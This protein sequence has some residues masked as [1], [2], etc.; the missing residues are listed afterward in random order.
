M[1]LA[2]MACAVALALSNAEIKTVHVINSCHLDV[3]F[4]SP[5]D[6]T[7]KGPSASS[8][9]VVNL[10][11]DKHLPRAAAV[12]AELRN[13][14]FPQYTDTKLAFMFQSWIIDLFFDCPAGLGVHCPSA[15]AMASVRAAILEGDITWH[16][17]PHNAQ[18]EI[19]DPSLIEA[20]LELTSAIDRRF[21]RS[22]TCLE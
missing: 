15:A 13:G 6:G 11:F 18:L 1:M 14:S 17:F 12:A 22:A 8:R 21:S 3:G 4:A 16:A 20:G 9:E 19:M 10:Y 7:G 2:M 5:D